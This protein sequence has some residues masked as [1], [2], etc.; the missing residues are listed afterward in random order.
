MGDVK[1]Y[2]AEKD[3]D[4]TLPY[5]F[6]W[7]AWVPSGDS[8]ASAAWN[9]TSP[10]GDGTPITVSSTSVSS[11]V[12]SATLTAG[13]AGNEYQARCRVTTTNGLIDDRTI[14]IVVR[15]R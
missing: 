15:E 11:N 10:S 8:V 2:V 1:R 9:I 4:A 5:G 14:W 6:D 13:T 3:P 12:A 7:S